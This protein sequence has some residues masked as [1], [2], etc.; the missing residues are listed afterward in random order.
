MSAIPEITKRGSFNAVGA[1]VQQFSGGI[2]SVIAG[3]I[4]AQG[5]TGELQR[6]DVLGYIVISTTLVS[7]VLMYFINKVVNEGSR[8]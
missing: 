6:F 7:L 4:V 2:A 5:P 8:T 1:S 3:L